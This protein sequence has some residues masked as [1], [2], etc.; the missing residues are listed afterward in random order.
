MIKRIAEALSTEMSGNKQPPFAIS[1]VMNISHPQGA[2]RGQKIIDQGN[3]HQSAELVV[4]TLLDPQVRGDKT[5]GFIL[6]GFSAGGGVLIEAARLLEKKGAPYTLVLIDP[7]ATSSHKDL[8]KKIAFDVNLDIFRYFRLE[9]EKTRKKEK[10]ETGKDKTPITFYAKAEATVSEIMDSMTTPDGAP[11][12]V[13]EL[14]KEWFGQGQARLDKIAREHGLSKSTG[15]P[16]PNLTLLDHDVTKTARE[17]LKG[18]VVL[19]SPVFAKAVNLLTSRGELTD[20]MLQ[21]IWGYHITHEPQ[22]HRELFG[23]LQAKYPKF[24]SREIF[25]KI[26]QLTQDNYFDQEISRIA[27]K[28]F[29]NAQVQ[30]M[31]IFAGLHSGILRNQYLYES[32]IK[33]VLR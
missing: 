18:K 10:R 32:I 26:G 30:T 13:R 7:A 5:K 9:G 22:Y 20:H 31:P 28:L 16:A 3:L 19:I 14:A 1:A 33:S 4:E 15:G 11:Q 23:L 21:T 27:H 12:N 24:N 25:Q 29:P 8:L 6:W 2:P 17:S